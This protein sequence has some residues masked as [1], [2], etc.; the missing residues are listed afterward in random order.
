MDIT[1][2]YSGTTREL[3]G[4]A[5]VAEFEKADDALNAV[6]RIQSVNRLLIGNRMG[7]LNPHTRIGISYGERISDG[8]FT[9]GMVV[10]RAQMQ[11]QL[12]GVDEILV[13]NAFRSQLPES[14]N[15]RL[16]YVG[17]VELKGLEESAE[18]Y[19]PKI[20]RVDFNFSSI[21]VS[22]LD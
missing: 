16:E 13:D 22:Y 7:R 17:T 20:D 5:V 10:I 1:Y 4:D 2:Q 6:I 18:S 3:R 15:P 21:N 11:E 12:V 9:T 19:R 8:N 14:E